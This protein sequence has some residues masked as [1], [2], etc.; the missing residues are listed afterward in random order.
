LDTAAHS[1][2]VR[3]NVQELASAHSVNTAFSKCLYNRESY[4]KVLSSWSLA[5]FKEVDKGFAAII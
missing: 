3:R 2:Q 4:K 1:R 5:Q